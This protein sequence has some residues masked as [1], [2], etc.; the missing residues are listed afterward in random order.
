MRTVFFYLTLAATLLA[1]CHASADGKKTEA[2]AEADTLKYVALSF[3]DGPN[4]TIT[5]RILDLME[6]YEVTGSFFVIGQHITEESAAVMK[7]A[8]DM[9]C[10]IQNHS[11]THSMMTQLTVAQMKE[12]VERTSQL[13]EQYTGTRPTLFRPPYINVNQTMHDSIPLI[14][15]CGE[16]SQDWEPTVSAEQRAAHMLETA[17]DGLIYLLH[18]FEGNE[19]TVQALDSVIPAL[20]AR[21]FAFTTVSGLFKAKGIT[22]AKGILYTNVLQKE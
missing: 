7:R 12:E 6:K 3:D 10:E 9:G 17:A 18:D 16:G 19:A 11:L 13:I 22:P 21:G 1:G 8:C 15:I 4:T 20:K 14:F 5:P 2:G